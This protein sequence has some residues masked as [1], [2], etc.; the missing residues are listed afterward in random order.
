[1]CWSH[2]ATARQSTGKGTSPKLEEGW[3]HACPELFLQTPDQVPEL[4]NRNL[5]EAGDRV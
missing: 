2:A 1:M 4:I 3:H 5:R